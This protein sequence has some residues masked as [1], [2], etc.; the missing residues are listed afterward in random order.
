MAG[1]RSDR[2]R[3]DETVRLSERSH[4]EDRDQPFQ[5]IADERQDAE[6]TAGGASDVGCPD[7]AATRGA[8]V[9][10]RDPAEQH[11]GRNGSDQ[12]GEYQDDDGHGSEAEAAAPRA[13]SAAAER[14]SEDP[15]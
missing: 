12:I 14:R 13:W 15:A 3:R 11:T 10:A 6:T 2:G 1:S 7:V 8:N 4:D 9:D 5:E